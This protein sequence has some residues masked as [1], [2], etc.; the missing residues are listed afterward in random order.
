MTYS[1]NTKLSLMANYDY[2]HD[3]VLPGVGLPTAPV[4][5]TGLAGYIKYAFND[6]W[7]V[8]TRGEWFNDHNGFST[9]TAQNA[10]EFT[11]TLQRM[12]AS[13]IISRLEFRRDMSDH[14]VFPYRSGLLRDSQNTL[15][16]GLVYAFSSADAK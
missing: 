2:G 6:R 1:P 4:W 11:L 12:I 16:A 13:K 3:R 9:G 5:W 10:S 15:T 8:A 14:N 7:A